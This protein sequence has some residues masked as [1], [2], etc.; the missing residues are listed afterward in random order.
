MVQEIWK[1][2]A[3]IIST[4]TIVGKKEHEGPL[5]AHFDAY[6]HTG[7][8]RF[9][10]DTWEKAEAEMQHR[11]LTHALAR[12]GLAQNQVD[13]LLAGDLMNQCISS[14][15]GLLPFDI[16]Y[17]GLYGACSTCAEALLLGACMVTAGFAKRAAAVTS[18]HNAA[19]ER[20]FRFPI[21]YGGQRPPT[22]HQLQVKTEEI[23]LPR[24][25]IS[26]G[27]L[28]SENLEA[29]GRNRMWLD[30][31]LREQGCT[32]PE[33]VFLLLVDERG[34]LCLTRKDPGT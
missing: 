6:D 17:M 27:K 10:Q 29:L 13:V 2:N 3:D 26:D 16:P 21:E 32:G 30:R 22:A 1:L 24:V 12:A 31:R 33:Q 34:N 5:A 18:S 14:A 15:Y 28:L 19:A 23:G 9:E 4:A 25:V 20:Q 11:A 7:S 8:D